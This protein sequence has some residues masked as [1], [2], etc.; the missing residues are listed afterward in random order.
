M[1][2]QMLSE[3]HHFFGNGLNLPPVGGQPD[4]SGGAALTY[5]R[6]PAGCYLTALRGFYLLGKI[7]QASGG[8][9][10]LT[11]ISPHAQNHREDTRVLESQRI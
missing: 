9:T 7:S 2:V 6:L 11:P 4:P 5:N 3:N 1:S 10:S 8:S